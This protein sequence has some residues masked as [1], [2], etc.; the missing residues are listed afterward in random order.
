[1]SNAQPPI[2]MCEEYWRNTQLSIAHIYGGITYNGH[3]YMYYIAHRNEWE[4]SEGGGVECWM[5]IP[6]IE[7]IKL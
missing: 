7:E 6:K 5:P 1:M 3:S 2:C 4:F